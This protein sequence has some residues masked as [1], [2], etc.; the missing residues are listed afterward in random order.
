MIDDEGI[1]RLGVIAEAPTDLVHLRVQRPDMQRL[2]NALRNHP[3]LDIEDR[4][5]EILAFLD[6]GRIAGPQ[7]VERKLASDLQGRLIDDFKVNGV[8]RESLPRYWMG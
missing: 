6:D 4:K 1:A 3:A 8:Q 2:R 7:H 5:G